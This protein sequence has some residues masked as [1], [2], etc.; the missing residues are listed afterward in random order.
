MNELENMGEGDLDSRRFLQFDLGSENYAIPLLEVKEVIPLPETTPLPNS[1]AYYVGIMNL[2]GQIISIVDL[3]KRLKI[4]SKK[5]GLEEAVV[6]IEIEGIA[7]GVV[8]DSINRVLNIENHEV[9]EVPEVKSQV[10]AQFIQG[11]YKDEDKLTVFLDLETILNI[12]EIK[13]TQSQAA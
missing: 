10:N 3:R 1:P 13:K 8:V 9:A 5:E 12:R 11:V 7:I 4:D 6:I 2:R